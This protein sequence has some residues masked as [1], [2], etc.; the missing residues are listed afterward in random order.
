MTLRKVTTIHSIPPWLAATVLLA[1]V[2][3]PLSGHAHKLNLFAF[4]ENNQVSIESYF[5]DGKKARNS[6]VQ[7]LDAQGKV[8]AAGVTDEQGSFVFGAPSPGPLRIVVNAGMGHLAEYAL[9]ADDLSGAPNPSPEAGAGVAPLQQINAPSMPA[10][11]TDPRVAGATSD[12]T[13]RAIT[14]AIKPLAAEIAQLRQRT[15]LADIIGGIGLIMGIL[16]AIGY[17]KARSLANRKSP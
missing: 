7:V 13:L 3:A 15:T 9:S 14:H 1:M 17:F 6:E 16:G 5:P 11:P 4:V 8:L 2:L 12:E 10:P